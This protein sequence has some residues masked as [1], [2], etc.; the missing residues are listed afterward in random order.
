MTKLGEYSHIEVPADDVGRAQRFYE[1]VFGWQF[2][3]MDE[4]PG[5]VLYTAGPGDMGGGIG[6]RGQDAGATIRNYL[7]C[8]DLDATIADVAANGGAVAT[9][10]TDI[11][12]GW[13]AVVTDTEGNE[14]GLYQRKP[15]A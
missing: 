6:K 4:L 2:R 13:Y 10:K 9:P 7:G 5:Y 8:E 12:F 11:G 1:Q 3:P 14:I 15:D